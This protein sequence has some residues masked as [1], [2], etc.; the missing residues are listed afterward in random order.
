LVSLNQTY[1]VLFFGESRFGTHSRVSHG[2]FK[3]GSRANIQKKLGYQNFY[4]HGAVSPKT[5]DNFSLTMPHVD[6]DWMNKILEEFSLNLKSRT[7][8]VVDQ[9]GW[10]KSLDLVFSNNIKIFISL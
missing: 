8:L 10:H 4:V 3:T 7:I 1:E 9:A 6:V 2:C 5:G